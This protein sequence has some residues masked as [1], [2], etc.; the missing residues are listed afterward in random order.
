VTEGRTWG[1]EEVGR[2]TRGIYCGEDGGREN[3]DLLERQASLEQ[4]RNLRQRKFPGTHE[5]EPG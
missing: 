4:T 1:K 2:G 5:D 3:L